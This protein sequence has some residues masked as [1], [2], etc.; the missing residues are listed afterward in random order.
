M[1]SDAF[2]QS[3][4]PIAT[5]QHRHDAA[6]AQFVGE[7][8]HDARDRRVTRLADT[9]LAR[10]LRRDGIYSRVKPRPGEPA[11]SSQAVLLDPTFS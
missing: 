5:F 7:S 1:G 10:E 6:L 9:V 3:I 8:N 2:R 11:V 4:K